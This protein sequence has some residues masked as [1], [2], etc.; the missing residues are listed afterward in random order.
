MTSVRRVHAAGAGLALLAVIA[1]TQV[2]GDSSG[3]R[4]K[5]PS[6]LAAAIRTPQDAGGP[7]SDES[8]GSRFARQPVVTY[9][10]LQGELHFALQVKPNL[11]EVPARPRDIAVVIDT[12]ASQVGHP[13]RNARAI[14]AEVVKA[15]R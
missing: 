8:A 2:W 13:L 7:A 1:C 5:K 14:T 10:T 12:S 3:N 11:G 6:V 15:G 4:L 9:E